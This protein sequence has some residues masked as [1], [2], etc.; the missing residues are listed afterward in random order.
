MAAA[1][2]FGLWKSAGAR[3]QAPSRVV[4]VQEEGDWVIRRIGAYLGEGVRSRDIPFA[5]ADTPRF[6]YNSLVHFGSVH[7]FVHG[8]AGKTHASNR[9]MITMYHGDMGIS[10]EFDET[11]R[12]V[13]EKRDRIARTVVSTTLMRKRLIGWGMDPARIALIP[14]GVELS[15]FAPMSADERSAARSGLGIPEDALCVGSFQKDGNGWGEGLEPK[16]IKGPDLFVEAVI[17]L[18]RRRK[19]HCLLTG[20]ARGYVKARLGQAGIPF[21]H[22]MLPDYADVARMYGCLDIYLVTSREEGGPM[23]IM[24][25]MASGVPL[26]TTFVG[27][28]PDVIRDRENGM[29]SKALDA[30]SIA[31]AAEELLSNRAL[32][33]RCIAAARQDVKRL[34]W[35]EIAASYANL[36]REL[37]DSAA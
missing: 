24:E 25:S 13:L 20:P 19:V 27:M 1:A 8:G 12:I 34:D 37:L 11:L 36:Y 3:V 10:T 32:R 21:T 33:E 14:I 35:P 5:V 30:D 15:A 22:R 9:V 23:S 7:A 2:V 17:R 18:A 31:S 4:Y 6:R 28:A 16:L 26:V 29:I